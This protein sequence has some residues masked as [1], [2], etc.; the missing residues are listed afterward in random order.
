MMDVSATQSYRGG[1]N[2]STPLLQERSQFKRIKTVVKKCLCQSFERTTRGKIQTFAFAAVNVTLW[3]YLGY[4]IGSQIPTQSSARI[5]FWDEETCSFELKGPAI[6]GIVVGEFV[7]A[8]FNMC[9]CLC[10]L[11][12]AE[13]ESIV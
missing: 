2:A 4:L 13:D 9:C 10:V 7:A 5:C 6:F 12:H 3:G 1:N 11:H 8:C